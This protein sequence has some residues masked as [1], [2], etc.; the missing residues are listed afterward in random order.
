MSHHREKFQ[1][2]ASFLADHV[3]AMV[4]ATLPELHQAQAMMEAA[5]VLND[6]AAILLGRVREGIEAIERKEREEN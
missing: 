6:A 3:L 2:L 5:N 4:R 1:G